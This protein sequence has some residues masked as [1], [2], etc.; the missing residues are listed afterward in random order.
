[1]ADV[2]IVE[3]EF[4]VALD[5]ED[6]IFQAGHGIIGVVADKRGIAEISAAPKVALV[7]LNLRDGRTGPA[8]ARELA[9]RFGTKIIFVTANPDQIESP[10]PTALGYIRKPFNHDDVLG[11]LALAM[12]TARAERPRGLHPLQ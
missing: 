1:M 6:I 8:I 4:L 3:D 7:D 10:P 11:A 2:L 9:E 12:G 5:L